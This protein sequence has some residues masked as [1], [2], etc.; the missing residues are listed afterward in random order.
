MLNKPSVHP[1]ALG[2]TTFTMKNSPTNNHLFIGI[3]IAT[4]ATQEKGVKYVQN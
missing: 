3:A 2:N 4:I 1:K